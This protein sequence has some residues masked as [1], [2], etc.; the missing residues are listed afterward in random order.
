MRK[1]IYLGLILVL[2]HLSDTLKANTIKIETKN[3]SLIY[4]VNAST[5]LVFQYYGTKLNDSSPLLNN[6]FQQREQLRY[7]ISDPYNNGAYTSFGNTQVDEPAIHAIHSDG[8]LMTDL[9]YNGMHTEPS[10]EGVEHTVIRL[11]DARFD[12]EVALH[13]EAFFEEDII[14]QWVVVTNNEKGNV[15]LKNFYSGHLYLTT[16]KYYLTHFSG[17]WGAEMGMQEEELTNGSKVIETKKG[18][19]ATLTENSAFLIALQHPA[20]ENEGE[21]IGGALAWSGNF[22]MQFQVNEWNQLNVLGG[23]NPFLSEVTLEKGEKFETPK[24]LFTY[25][26]KGRGQVSRNMH[27][28]ARK[29]AL[30]NGFSPRPIVLNSWEGSYF[31]F[32][33][34]KLTDMMDDASKLGIEIFVLDDGWFGNEY[35]R[36]S[37]DAGLGDWQVNKKK[38][39][40]GISYLAEYAQQKGMRFGLWIEP[41]MVNPQ[42]ELAKKHPDWVIQSP[43]R[44]KLTFRNQWVLDL[45]NPK[46]REYIWNTVDNLL[47]SNPGIAYIKWD[48]NRH[49]NQVGS[50][51]LPNDKQSE[52][53]IDYVNGLY[54][55]YDKIRTKYPDLIFQ[56]CSSGGGRVD[57]G[58]LRFHQE[59]WP[60]DNT[61]P[62][63]RVFTQYGTTMIYPPIA[64]ASHVT[65][66]GNLV[67][68][69]FRFDLAM[70]GRLGVELQPNDF[71]GEDRN[72]AINAINTYKGIRSII[73]AGD[74]FR[75]QS[76]YESG[77]WNSLMYV[78]KDKSK[79][80]VFAFSL[81]YHK[82]GE[83]PT[84][85][86][87][88]LDL[89]KKYR[90]TELNKMPHSTWGNLEGTSFWGNDEILSGDFLV[91]SGMELTITRPYDSAVFLL[92]V[93]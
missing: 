5:H 4:C 36:N 28:W 88:G 70:T 45:A 91:K 32:N 40:K 51:Y 41:E 31:D 44:E 18:V 84:I 65:K 81:G 69:K 13:L 71:A 7:V 10:S 83:F 2:L 64:M 93:E 74:L 24:L 14:N 27:D 79:A 11:K 9:V 66:S 48:A 26:N 30:V 90:V 78:S 52:C 39:P 19:R 37:D 77:N 58:S 12:F 68:L 17:S 67:P 46:V 35:P 56:V 33:E 59:F 63:Q 72:F 6:K 57:F 43:E 38:L 85:Q 1:T 75:I 53:W 50:P 62:V 54:S 92:D 15:V 21:V 29:Y 60:S 76:P 55:I 87:K 34:K 42:S 49:I 89:N 22:K 80:V 73:A 8:S 25:S 47:S 61:D 3:S 23:I 82:Q 86:L 16:G 20:L